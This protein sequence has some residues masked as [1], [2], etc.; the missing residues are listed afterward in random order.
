VVV[1]DTSAIHSSMFVL[2]FFESVRRILVVLTNPGLQT[3]VEH[4]TRRTGGKKT[5]KWQPSEQARQ[6][7]EDYV[8]DQYLVYFG[9]RMHVCKTNKIFCEYPVT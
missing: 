8:A 5:E 3:K 6:N 7:L 9:L 1:A 2:W 4:E